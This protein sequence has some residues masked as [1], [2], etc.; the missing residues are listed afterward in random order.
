MVDC[1][2]KPTPTKSEG[3]LGSDVNGRPASKLW[4]YASVIGMLLYLASNLRP[5]IAFAVHQC[6]RFSHRPMKV[7]ED[8]DKRIV[9]YLVGTV[10]K[11]LIFRPQDEIVLEAFADADFAGLWNSEDPQDP[12][13]VKSRTGYLI[14]LGKVPV[15]WKS[16]LQ[17]LIAVSTM[18]AEYVALSMCMRELI[19]LRRVLK[20]IQGVLNFKSSVS[21]AACTL[22]EDNQGAVTLANVPRMTPRSKHIAIPYHFFRE[23][24]KKKEVEV[25]HISTD[26]QLADLL[27]KG[28]VEVKFKNLRDKL[29]G[30]CE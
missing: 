20:E 27:T 19:P 7:H 9:W 24:V 17:T 11:G 23:H 18:E 25:K 12:T 22:F 14:R 4:S 30:W 21:S 29:M 10:E 6:A 2:V 13:C 26:D 5:D 28:L 16:K 15:V 3:P 8:A 1:N